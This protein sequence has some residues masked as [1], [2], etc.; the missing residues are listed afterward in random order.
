MLKKIERAE[1]DKSARFSMEKKTNEKDF[2]AKDWRKRYMKKKKIDVKDLKKISPRKRSAK[3]SRR[4]IVH[5]HYAHARQRAARPTDKMHA[6][7]RPP[8]IIAHDNKQS[9]PRARDGFQPC[10]ALNG[11]AGAVFGLFVGLFCY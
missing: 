8:A 4:P 11:C 7:A 9:H 5:A 1:K 3:D 2:A 6:P 10:A